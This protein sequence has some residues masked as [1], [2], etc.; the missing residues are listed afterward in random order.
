[1]ILLYGIL[2]RLLTLK[3]MNT[4]P[5]GDDDEDNSYSS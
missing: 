1:M 4:L 2:T 3:D 5:N